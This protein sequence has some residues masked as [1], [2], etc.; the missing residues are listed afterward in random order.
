MFAEWLT[1]PLRALLSVLSSNYSSRQVAAGA[2]LGVMLGF[3]P[4]ATLIAV[5]LG[6][7][8][9]ALRVNRGMG[10]LMAAMVGSLAHFADP[11]SHRLGLWLLTLSPMQSTYAAVYEAPLGPWWGFHNSVVVGSLLLGFYAAYPVYLVVKGL[12][13]RFRPPAVRWAS[14]YR[15]GRLLLGIELTATLGEAV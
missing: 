14:R 8:L 4:K 5:V 3:V 12:V 2:A 7:L 9:C 10:L 1:R 11:W 15:L 13:D 6:V